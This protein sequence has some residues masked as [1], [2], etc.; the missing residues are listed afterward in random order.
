VNTDNTDLDNRNHLPRTRNAA[1][2]HISNSRDGFHSTFG[3]IEDLDYGGK[4]GLS[5]SVRLFAQV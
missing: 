4:D 2:K 3:N 5:T 1:L